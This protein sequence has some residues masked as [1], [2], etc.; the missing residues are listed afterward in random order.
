MMAF[1]EAFER[2]DP[3]ILEPIYEMEVMVPE[4][5]MGDVMTDLQTRRSVITGMDSKD[6]YQIIKAKTP[7]AE[8]YRYTTSLKSLTQGRATFN[9]KFS[10]Y[11]PVPG[12]IQKKL[13]EHHKDSEN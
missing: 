8:L 2:A 10:E 6:S 1:K 5:L 4:E 13:A 3:K 11:A 7:L 9:T 12:E